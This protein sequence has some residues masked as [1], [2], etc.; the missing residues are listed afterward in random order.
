M[1]VLHRILGSKKNFSIPE[2]FVDYLSIN[3]N[4]YSFIETGTFK[5]GSIDLVKNYVLE[6]HSCEP[7]KLYYDYSRNKFCDD[8][9]VNIYNVTSIEMLSMK[10]NKD[11]RFLYWIDSHYKGEGTYGIDNPC[12]LMDEMSIVLPKLKVEDILLIDDARLFTMPAFKNRFEL[13]PD[14]I[15]IA[16]IIKKYECSFYIFKD[17]IIIGKKSQH[18]YD[19]L[20]HILG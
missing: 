2:E 15:D 11:Q 10:F 7:A 3:N 6:I 19:F 14:L 18:L 16:N 12:P 13:W 17:T 5:G 20:K 9:K 8:K 1:N 4:Q